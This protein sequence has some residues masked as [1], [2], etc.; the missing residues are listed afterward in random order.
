MKKCY[1]CK[2]DKPLSEFGKDKQR[3]DGVNPECKACSKIRTKAWRSVPANRLKG[4]AKAKEWGATAKGTLSRKNTR[5]KRL[6]GITHNRFLEMIAAANGKCRIC[7]CRLTTEP[8]KRSSSA[9]LDHCHETARV[10]GVL[11]HS[12]NAGIGQ[13]NDSPRLLRRALSYLNAGKK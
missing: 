2:V 4:L 12:C 11:C 8:P 7:D 1:A 5:Y 3:S 6:Y 9:V 13:L 10:R